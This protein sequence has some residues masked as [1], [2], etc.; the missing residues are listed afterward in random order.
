MSVLIETSLGDLVVDLEVDKCPITC[1]N[2]LKLCRVKYYGLNAFFNVSKDFIAQV[3]DPTATGQGGESFES[4]QWNH[5][6]RGVSIRGEAARPARYFRPE[7]VNSLKHSTKGTLS[8]AVAPTVVDN[9]D[10]VETVGGCGSQ[11]FFTLADNI[12]YLDGKHAVFGHVVEGLDVLDKLN[13]IFVDQEGR[14]LKDVRIRHV[15]VLGEFF[16]F[17]PLYTTQEY[18]APMHRF[19]M[20]SD[21]ILVFNLFLLGLPLF[22]RFLQRIHSRTLTTACL[23]RPPL[24]VHLTI[25]QSNLESA[26]MNP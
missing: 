1:N 17:F 26:K 2:F 11:F 5:A 9:G 23:S 16:S 22:F 19:K 10:G 4:W 13:E 12:E 7:I 15:E 20:S 24:P 18:I 8:M 6:H 14:P 21:L 3:G 25:H